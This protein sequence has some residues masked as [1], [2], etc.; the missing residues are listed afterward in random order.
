MT[1]SDT[2]LVTGASGQLGRKVVRELLAL[3][4][5]VKAHFRNIEKANSWCPPNAMPVIG[6]LLEP[7]WM[8]K[9]FSGCRY[10]IHCAAKVSLR[11]AQY[12]PMYQVNVEGTR[13]VVNACKIAGVGRLVHVSSTAAVGGSLTDESL[14][15]TASFN[16]AGYGIPYFETK[17]ESEQVA[18]AANGSTLEVVV[19]NPSIMISPPDREVTAD[20]L[21][22]IPKRL[23][24]YFE[25]GVNLV[26]AGDVV[27]GIILAMENGRP[28]QR[29][30]LAG[31]NIDHTRALMLANKYLGM[32]N[33]FIKLP[34]WSLYLLGAIEE[35]VYIFRNRKPRL[36]RAIAR[37]AKM[38]F[39]WSSAKAGR[40]LGWQAKPLENTIERIMAS[41]TGNKSHKAN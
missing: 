34:L 29:Y 13:A 3:G 31:E 24:A 40:E 1:N 26:E 2:V 11:P 23:P 14:D 5:A 35:A 15:E 32:K 33:P 39:Y 12:E 20:D 25:F 36:N 7:D 6:D 37:L 27:R 41:V 30:I 8:P 38:R 18:L 16:L 22:K 28:G 10:V 19:V 9:A 4:Y 17:H 21:R